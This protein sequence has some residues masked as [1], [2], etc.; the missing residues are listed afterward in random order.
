MR[1]RSLGKGSDK[2]KFRPWL[3]FVRWEQTSPP[4]LGFNNQGFPSIRMY[5]IKHVTQRFSK[6]LKELLQDSYMFM[7]P[8]EIFPNFP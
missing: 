2:I 4:P 6:S 5:P 3:E 1:V 8:M 7:K